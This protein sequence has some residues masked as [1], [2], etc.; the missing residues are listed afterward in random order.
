MWQDLQV[1]VVTTVWF[2]VTEVAKLAWERWHESHLAAPAGT[3]MCVVD[4]P[5]AVLPLWQVSHVPVPTA[6]AAE[7]AKVT[8]AQLV[9]DLWQLSQLPVTVAWVALLGVPTAIR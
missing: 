6:L 9:V 3:G 8:V 2:I 1:A 5:L 4:L 7:C